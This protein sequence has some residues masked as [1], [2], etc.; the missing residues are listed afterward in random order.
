MIGKPVALI[1]VPSQRLFG[2]RA[3]ARY[4]G[5]CEDSLRKYA[6]LGWIKARRLEKRRVFTLEDLDRFIESLPEYRDLTYTRVGGKPGGK[7][8]ENGS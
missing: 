4:L 8:I 1:Q 6:D 3:A 2:T 7:E 5:V